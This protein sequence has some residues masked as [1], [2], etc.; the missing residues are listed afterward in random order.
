MSMPGHCRS[1]F[2]F[3]VRIRQ[4]P[5]I[6]PAAMTDQG[7]IAT[8]TASA[9]TTPPSTSTPLTVDPSAPRTMPVVP[10]G[11]QFGKMFSAALVVAAVKAR[12]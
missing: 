9:S 2:D 6:H 5:S 3:V 10:P 1:S 12:G 8:T 4:G 11:A 7:P